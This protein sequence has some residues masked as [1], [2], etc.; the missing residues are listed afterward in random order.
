MTKFN[1]LWWAKPPLILNY[2]V[3]VLSVVVALILAWWIESVW[4]SVP[5]VSLFLCAVMFSAWFGGIRPAL[6][7]IA[8]SALAFDYYFTLASNLFVGFDQGITA[9]CLFC[10]I[11]P[12]YC[13]AER[14]AKERGR[15]AQTCAR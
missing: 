15:L 8:F 12:F 2:G 10:A 6:L 11:S 1:P 4:Q 5:P 7:A 13:V 3:A 14:R 9:P